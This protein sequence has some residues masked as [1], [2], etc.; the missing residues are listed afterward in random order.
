V[1]LNKKPFSQGDE[2]D[3]PFYI[4]IVE[5]ISSKTEVFVR[6]KL[7]FLEALLLFRRS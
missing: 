1:A 6:K 2:L 3:C 7:Y 5:N 4:G